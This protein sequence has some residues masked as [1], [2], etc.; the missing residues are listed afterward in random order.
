MTDCKCPF[1]YASALYPHLDNPEE[2]MHMIV[3]GNPILLPLLK[4]P[5]LDMYV[6]ATFDCTSAPFYL[7]LIFM[8]YLHK[9]SSYAP[10]FDSLLACIQYN[11]VLLELAD[12]SMHQHNR[13]QAWSSETDGYSV[14]RKVGRRSACGM[15]LSSQ[16]A[17]PWLSG[18]INCSIF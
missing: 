9:T 8:V 6:D 3:F 4:V 15:S 11:R 16:A 12:S 7:T 14:L 18:S 13:L 17:R 5:S 10:V 2:C 1:L